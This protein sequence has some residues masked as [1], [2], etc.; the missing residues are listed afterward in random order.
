MNCPVIGPLQLGVVLISLSFSLTDSL[1]LSTPTQDPCST[2]RRKRRSA[3]RGV[4]VGEDEAVT[5][6]RVFIIG[7]VLPEGTVDGNDVITGICYKCIYH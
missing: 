2:A 4:P 6:L 5:S 1:T 7:S 3:S